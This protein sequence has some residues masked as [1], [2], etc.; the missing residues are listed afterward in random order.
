MPGAAAD[1]RN[2]TF[3]R[4]GARYSIHAANDFDT[5]AP[6]HY[7]ANTAKAPVAGQHRP[8]QSDPVI[9]PAAS[10]TAGLRSSRIAARRDRHVAGAGP[11][12]VARDS[13][14]PMQAD[15]PS[16][17]NLLVPPMAEPLLKTP[18]LHQHIC[19]NFRF[20]LNRQ[21]DHILSPESD[22]AASILATLPGQRGSHYCR[23]GW[24]WRWPTIIDRGQAARGIV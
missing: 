6:A 9:T 3:Q 16:W 2:V 24:C 8:A 10:T 14:K 5:P 21:H 17:K 19:V 15:S 4:A 1:V 13:A 18:G 20:H 11:G 7:V 23:T 22:H 12:A